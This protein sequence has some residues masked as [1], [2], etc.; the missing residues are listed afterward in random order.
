MKMKI[1]CIIV[2]VLFKMP[3]LY[4]N[5]TEFEIPN[6]RQI[7]TL[8]LNKNH[9]DYKLIEALRYYYNFTD[10]LQDIPLKTKNDR[11]KC[12]SKARDLIGEFVQVNDKPIYIAV[13]GHIISVSLKYEYF[14]FIIFSAKKAIQLLSEAV[15]KEPEN[16]EIRYYRLT[17][18]TY[19]PKKY[20]D[21]QEVILED[22]E[23]VMNWLETFSN[24]PSGYP[25]FL[26]TY[27]NFCMGKYYYKEEKDNQKALFYFKKIPDNLTPT[28]KFYDERQQIMQRIKN[29]KANENI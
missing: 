11:K 18:F 20:Y 23:I 25:A 15:I 27:V 21:F 1:M 5:N 9:D 28:P 19:Y 14:P 24:D 17:S 22:Y 12:I 6:A 4:A 10:Q 2:I 16:P 7:Q 3:A 13:Q 8:K 29:V 26:K